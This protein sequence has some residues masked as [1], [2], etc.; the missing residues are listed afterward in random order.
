LAG[1]DEQ[2]DSDSASSAG[3]PGPLSRLLQ[4]LAE[5]PGDGLLDAWKNELRPGARVGRFEILREVGHG[6]FGAVFEAFDTELNRV[7]AVK[8]LR[9]SRPRRDL[10]TDWVKKEAEAVAR[11]DHPCI[12]TLFDMGTC[13]SGAY[14]VM[15]LLHGRTLAQRIA[16][17]P[18]PVAEALRIAEEMAKGLAHAHQRGVL[19]RDLKPSNVFLCDDGRVKLLDFGLAN[20]LGSPGQKG[21]GTPAYMAPE[22]ARGEEVDERSDVYA[23]AIVLREMIS[24]RRPGVRAPAPASGACPPEARTELMWERQPELA[25]LPAS[26]AR[27][28]LAGAPRPAAKAIF[29]ALSTEPSARP[30]DASAW[31]A[32]LRSARASLER[33]RR[34]RRVTVFAAVFVVLGIAVAGLATWRV[35]E[36]QIPRGRPTVAV[37]DFSNETGETELDALSGLLITSLEQGT[38]LRVLTR[39]RMFDVLQ[40][41]GKDGVERIDE[42]LAREVGRQ[43]RARALLLASIRKMGDG[44]VVEMRALDPLHDE[45]LFTVSDRATGKAGV[46]DLVDRLGEATRR[47]LSPGGA[48]DAGQPPKVA[49]ITTDSAK[50]WEL[51]LRARQALDMGKGAEESAR[52]ARAALEEDPQFPLAHFQLALASAA[53]SEWDWDGSS[54]ETRRHLAAAEKVADRLPEKERLLLRAMLTRDWEERRILYGQAAEAFPMDKELQFFAGEI[55]FHSDDVD[56]ALPLLERAV[57]LD[58]EYT[59]A[60]SHLWAA[61]RASGRADEK[62]DWLRRQVAAGRGLDLRALGF[63][64][65]DAGREEEAFQIL[66]SVQAGA[67][68]PWPPPRVAGYLAYVGRAQEAEATVRTSQANLGPDAT[69]TRPRDV[70]DLL[71]SLE[72]ALEDQGRLG[73]W[74]RTKAEEDPDPRNDIWVR[75]AVAVAGRD[76]VALRSVT[77]AL[78]KA[79]PHYAWGWAL[80]AAM[81][82]DVTVA[83]PLAAKM[84]AGEYG[85]EISRERRRLLGAVVAWG[86]GSTDVAVRELNAVADLTVASTRQIALLVLGEL[87]RSIGECRKAIEPLER[88]RAARWQP[89]LADDVLSAIPGMLHSLADCYERTGD[90]AKARERNAELLKRWARADPGLPLLVDAKA[91]QARLAASRK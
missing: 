12:V 76:L 31:L 47:K 85:A 5:A 62:L 43:T 88:A 65:L 66:R 35:W 13:P 50:A 51:L 15:E 14:L 58:P 7:V 6:G 11:L 83:G 21:A 28:E 42:P 8:T 33:P 26:V 60:A 27:S 61:Y 77:G 29:E 75:H 48:A 46:F 54:Q 17:G 82:G 39:G 59:L 55:H 34:M 81:A 69:T 56:A 78:E 2:R 24:G 63:G 91:M 22:Q 32:S 79:A 74:R 80:N 41:L 16:D 73:E 72:Y 37:A 84:L 44:Y 18:I 49:S 90:L 68:R 64:L 38:Q 87:H 19:H 86:N 89:P 52:L 67:G 25:P 40:Q 36:R 20:L 57:H 30:R 53:G 9:F 71:Q 4:E 3:A 1:T 23:A 70:K 45:Y 10:A